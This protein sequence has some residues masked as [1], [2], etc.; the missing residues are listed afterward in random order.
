M[1]Q[2]KYQERENYLTEKSLADQLK[3]NDHEIA[4]RKE[5]FNIDQKTVQCLKDTKPLVLEH[6]NDIVDNFYK[7]Q[8]HIKE[9]ELLIGDFETF[10][11]LHASMKRY[12][13]ELFEGFYDKEY[14]NNRL[15]IGKIHKRIGVSPKLY[16]SAVYNIEEIIADYITKDAQQRCCSAK[17]K[18]SITKHLTTKD[19]DIAE[20]KFI[21]KKSCFTCNERR[22]ALHKILMFDVQFIFDTYINSL[23]S[24]VDAAKNQVVEYAEGLEEIV[25]QR[26]E[27]LEDM[28]KKDIL[29]G[30]F[31]QRF[32]YEQ[33]RLEIARTE[34]SQQELSLVYFDLNHFKKLND[35]KG[36]KAGDALLALVGETLRAELR[37]IDIAFRYGGDEFCIIMP[38]TAS[39]VAE[40]VCLRVCEEFD[41]KE[42]Q[43]VTW[44]IGIAEIGHGNYVSM[45]QLVK[46]AD[47][48][49]YQAKSISREK[50]GHQIQ[51]F[52]E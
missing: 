33:L 19:A 25:R 13:I 8:K 4:Y 6:I 38:V 18:I 24:E 16:V 3:I 50:N 51:I 2:E 23:V 29:T 35:T 5:L 32:F 37:Q 41:K 36:H 28:S 14:V 47:K 45:D 49:M 31:N 39:S 43:G 12:I 44:S 26:T 1:N 40:S 11:R 30:L 42:T 34:R 46:M 22:L 10:N 21:T 17:E 9:I 27:Q 52:T 15:R 48:T 20:E 7:K